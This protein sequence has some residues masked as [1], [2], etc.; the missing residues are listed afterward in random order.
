MAPVELATA[1]ADA[2]GNID[3]D[4]TIPEGTAD[5]D[6]NIVAVNTDG[7]DTAESF[8]V[9]SDNEDGEDD[10]SEEHTSELQSR[11]QL[12][13]RLLLEDKKTMTPQGSSPRLGIGEHTLTRS[14]SPLLRH[15]YLPT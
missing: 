12:V 3:Q 1:I 9:K 14:S 13:C 11:G 15:G 2:D 6:Y 8:T 7:D 10:R 4:V 5:G